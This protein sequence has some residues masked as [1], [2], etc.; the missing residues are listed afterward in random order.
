[1][2]NKLSLYRIALLAWR[3]EL[4]AQAEEI[5]VYKE[6][7]IRDGLR[8]K[9]KELFGT[10]HEIELD[11]EGGPNDPVLGAV[12]DGLHFL[13]IRCEDG[14][15]KITMLIRCARCGHQMPSK[16]LHNISDLGQQLLEFE[17]SGILNDH[18]C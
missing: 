15:I 14:R 10:G 8:R 5:S 4:M 9:L 1:M 12:V 17:M 18:E 2:S 11:T 6:M 3:Q 13:G 7:T 16:F